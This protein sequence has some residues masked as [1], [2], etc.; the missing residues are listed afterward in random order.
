[1]PSDRNLRRAAM[2][3][4]RGAVAFPKDCRSVGKKIEY[5]STVLLPG[6]RFEEYLRLMGDLLAE[7]VHY[8][9]P[10]HELK[11]R[12]SVLEML[13]KYVPRASN[14]EFSFDLVVNGKTEVVWR[15]TM[16]VRPR[17][18]PFQ[19]TMNGL[20]HANVNDQGRI[21]YQREYYDPMESVEAIPLFGRFYKGILQMA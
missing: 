14:G 21:V 12:E 4:K 1:M 5:L 16:T 10:V 17:F 19:M 3:T 6:K 15:W 13:A 7:D 20:V 11:G 9:D 2:G 8:I 18:L